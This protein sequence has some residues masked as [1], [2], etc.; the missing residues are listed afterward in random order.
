MPW[1]PKRERAHFS[2]Q[3]SDED[4]TAPSS[5]TLWGQTLTFA[6]TTASIPT[7]QWSLITARSARN[8]PD[9]MTQSEPMTF[10]RYRAPFPI[11]VRCQTTVDWIDAPSSTTQPSPR[12]TFPAVTPAPT[13]QSL[14]STTFC[15]SAV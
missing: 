2:P 4:R 1:A 12:T 9:S 8:A 10:S 14:P 3:M 15:S 7:R 11:R 6:L 13:T 5:T